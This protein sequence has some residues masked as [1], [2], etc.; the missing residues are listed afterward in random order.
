MNYKR[1]FPRQQ[2]Q[3]RTF[4]RQ[5]LQ[6]YVFVLNR[7]WGWQ[8]NCRIYTGEVSRDPMG[9]F[10]QLVTVSWRIPTVLCFPFPRV[11]W[12]GQDQTSFPKKVSPRQRKNYW[13]LVLHKAALAAP[14]LPPAIE[15]FPSTDS[16]FC[17]PLADLD[18]SDVS[19]P[20]HRWTNGW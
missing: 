16:F 4:P 9:Y 14:F 2:S 12:C 10:I 1:T 5:Q 18:W 20:S 19:L 15:W 7:L 8:F 17:I 6:K 13:R 11:S 3:K